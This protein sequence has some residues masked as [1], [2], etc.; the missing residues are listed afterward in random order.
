MKK[1]MLCLLTSVL[2]AAT[3][4]SGCAV[5]KSE[6]S[7]TYNVET[8]D[9]IKITLN[10]MNGYSMNSEIPFTVVK[11][12]DDVMTGTFITEEGYDY[13][14][15]LI[16]SDADD[17]EII[18]TGEKDSNVYTFY[19]VDSESG[20]EYD[21]LVKVNDSATGVL[22]GSLTSEEDASAC[23]DALTFTKEK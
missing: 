13:Y 8:G 21:Y 6:M 17:V 1:K 12:E 14:H 22:M 15:E 9:S 7:Y 10:K 4:L 3:I 23:F 16:N 11:G 2:M 5:T 19:R 18:K 20:T